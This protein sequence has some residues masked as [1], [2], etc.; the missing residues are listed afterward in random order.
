MATISDIRPSITSLSY[1]E[2]ML[3]IRKCRDAR[4]IPKGKFSTK[5]KTSKTKAKR[6]INPMDLAK[7]LTDEQK[8]ELRKQLLGE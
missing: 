4:R 2:A 6:I 3:V 8:A 5:R 7:M 1:E